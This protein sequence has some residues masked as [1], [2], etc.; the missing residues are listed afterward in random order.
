[1]D[2]YSVTKQFRILRGWKIKQSRSK[3]YFA[4]STSFPKTKTAT[5][6]QWWGEGKQPDD[7]VLHEVLHIAF[8]ALEN[9]DKRKIK[10]RRD[11]EEKLIQDIC[12]VVCPSAKHGKW[13]GI[14]KAKTRQVATCSACKAVSTYRVITAYCPHCGAKM[15]EGQPS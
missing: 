10:E 2:I 5:I 7:Y 8:R 3:R 6:Y 11:V 13:T 14:I 12:R 1:M 9:M 15:K 4:Q